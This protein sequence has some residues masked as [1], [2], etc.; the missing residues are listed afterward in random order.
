MSPPLHAELTTQQAADLPKGAKN[1]RVGFT[2]FLALGYALAQCQMLP[3]F[4]V[5]FCH[6]VIRNIANHALDSAY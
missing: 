4:A 3:D 5:K 2:Y 1:R 6:E